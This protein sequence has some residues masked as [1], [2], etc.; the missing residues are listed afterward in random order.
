MTTRPPGRCRFTRGAVRPTIAEPH[1]SRRAD[2]LPSESDGSV[3][4]PNGFVHTR[5]ADNPPTRDIARNGQSESG[6]NQVSDVG[7]GETS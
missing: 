6:Q 7:C 1:S 5:V 3:V 2:A 4:P